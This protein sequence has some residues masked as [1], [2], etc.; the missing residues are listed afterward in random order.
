MWPALAVIG[1][2]DRSAKIT[3]AWQV[4]ETRKCGCIKKGRFYI[5][6]NRCGGS[7][8]QVK[9]QRRNKIKKMLPTSMETIQHGHGGG[10]YSTRYETSEKETSD[11][12]TNEDGGIC[13]TRIDR[14][15]RQK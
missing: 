5:I 11:A 4:G 1:R 3:E 12:K 8:L 6:G 2:D 7:C 9:K 10:N 15:G 14:W 13:N